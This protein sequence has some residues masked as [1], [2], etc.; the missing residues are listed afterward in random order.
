[1]YNSV[2]KLLISK[3][4]Q[5]HTLHSNVKN[6]QTCLYKDLQPLPEKIFSYHGFWGC[7]DNFNALSY[8]ER[9][10][11]DNCMIYLENEPYIVPG[12]Y[13]NNSCIPFDWKNESIKS[14]V[15][16]SM[17]SNSTFSKWEKCCQNAINCC[18]EMVNL[19]M[20][21]GG[22][23]CPAIWDG[24]TCY[25]PSKREQVVKKVC[26]PY[27]YANKDPKCHCEY[28]GIGFR[29]NTPRRTI[30]FMQ[31]KFPFLSFKNPRLNSVF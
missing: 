30:I 19:H 24:W 1:M 27:S 5:F 3:V 22:E 26:P 29:S 28:E 23:R 31:S 14:L 16:S 18:S 10:K 2:S 6:F 17:L 15:R 12:V 13:L 7:Y 9:I 8:S 21:N 25:E 11:S 20:K 4:S